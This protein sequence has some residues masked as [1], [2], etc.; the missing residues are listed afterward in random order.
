MAKHIHIHFAPRKRA[1]DQAPGS[2]PPSPMMPLVEALHAALAARE[3][4]KQDVHT[5]DDLVKGKSDAAFSKNVATEMHAGK[6]QKQ[7]LAIAYATKR[8][9]AKDAGFDESKVKRDEGGKFSAQQHMAA[10]E[11]HEAKAAEHHQQ[12]TQTTA[13]SQATAR[14]AHQEAADLHKQAAGHVQAQTGWQAHTTQKALNA[15]KLAN[16]ASAK[17]AGPASIDQLKAVAGNP[18]ASVE[19]RAAAVAQLDKMEKAANAVAASPHAVPEQFAH[20]PGMKT[21]AGME[22]PGWG[23]AHP[24]AGGSLASHKAVG[25]PTKSKILNTYIKKPGP[26]GQTPAQPPSASKP[27]MTL[28]G[29]VVPSEK[30]KAA[31]ALAKLGFHAPVP[32]PLG[33]P[34]YAPGAETP[35]KL[36]GKPMGLHPALAAV[37]PPGTA[38]AGSPQSPKGEINQVTGK[39]TSAKATATKAATHELLSSGHPFSVDELMKATGAKSTSTL[40]TA[41]S[42]LKSPKYAGKLGHLNIVKRPDGQYHVQKGEA[43][44]GAAPDKTAMIKQIATSSAAPEHKEAAINALQG[45]TPAGPVAP[46]V[47]KKT[48]WG[49]PKMSAPKNNLQV[50]AGQAMGNMAIK[51]SGPVLHSNFSATPQQ[52]AKLAANMKPAGAP[53]GVIHISKTLAALGAKGVSIK[54]V[55]K[56]PLAVQAKM[57]KALAAQ[58]HVPLQYHGASPP[59]AAPAEKPAS[60]L[61][62]EE[63][64]KAAQLKAIGLKKGA[65]LKAKYG[66]NPAPVQLIQK[67]TAAPSSADVAKTHPVGSAVDVKHLSGVTSP[68]KVIGHENGKVKVQYSGSSSGTG[69]HHPGAVKV[70]HVDPKSAANAYKGT[71]AGPLHIGPMKK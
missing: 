41:L 58:H 7:A 44:A 24:Y 56:N 55:G 42:D 57:V 51:S 33:K 49:T 43:A 31:N 16:E 32:K 13:S 65:S 62:Q 6:P 40:M 66:D 1:Q 45:P 34:T 59:A 18:K 10:A 48:I 5:E 52:S 21:P 61:L 60:P 19:E 20:E 71:H 36:T 35:V 25:G 69:L 39:P 38:P 54:H 9:A 67:F 15:T 3:G 53:E 47:A 12:Y 50:K 26:D 70:L 64:A 27:P 30:A 23:T 46:A 17:V 14:N 4:T 28:S 68:G 37:T 11:H 22:G 8:E 63:A 29:V 2:V